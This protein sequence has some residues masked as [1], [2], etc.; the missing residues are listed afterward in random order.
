MNKNSKHDAIDY[1]ISNSYDV[2]AEFYN[3]AVSEYH[4]IGKKDVGDACR[5]MKGDVGKCIL[6]QTL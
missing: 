2:E 3:V 6:L 4:C 5:D 1:V